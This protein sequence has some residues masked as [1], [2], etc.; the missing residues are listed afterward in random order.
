MPACRLL[1]LL[2]L[3]LLHLLPAAGGATES[4][5]RNGDTEAQVQLY[6]FWSASCPHCLTARPQIQALVTAHPWITLH[7]LELTGHP[8][9]IDRYV[10]M[11]AALGEEAS[12]VPALL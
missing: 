3:A 6:L 10:A 12:A 8:E 7:D 2:L 11:A 4:S 5:S 9:N 1:C